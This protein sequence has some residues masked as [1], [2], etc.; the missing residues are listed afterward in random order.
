MILS[1]SEREQTKKLGEVINKLLVLRQQ[2]VKDGK[3]KKR[4]WRF[5]IRIDEVKNYTT[6]QCRQLIYGALA[7]LKRGDLNSTPPRSMVM[8][9]ADYLDCT[10]EER[11]HL[12]RICQYALVPVYETGSDLEKSLANS[13]RSVANITVSRICYHERL[14]HSHCERV[15]SAPHQHK[16]CRISQY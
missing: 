7:E 14:G 15:Y 3:R 5:P 9:I 16:H 12:L 8:L 4:L 6:T 2:E 1:N 11:N 10:I 13:R